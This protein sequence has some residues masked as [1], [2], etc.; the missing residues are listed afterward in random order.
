M[1]GGMMN[2]QTVIKELQKCQLRVNKLKGR[3]AKKEIYNLIKV[4]NTGTKIGNRN[5]TTQFL[6]D[7]SQAISKIEVFEGEKGDKI[8][9][10]SFSDG[11]GC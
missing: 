1:E 6:T 11:L 10:F 2:V 8:F 4:L 7:Y 3:Y 9:V 5:L